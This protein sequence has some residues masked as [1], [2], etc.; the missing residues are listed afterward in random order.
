MINSQKYIIVFGLLFSLQSLAITQKMRDLNQV[1][2]ILMLVVDDDMQDQTACKMNSSR[3]ISLM[4]SAKAK[5]DSEIKKMIKMNGKKNIFFKV[6]TDQC[7]TDC[8]CGL[9]AYIGDTIGFEQLTDT[10]KLTH[11]KVSTIAPNQSKEFLQQC[12]LKNKKLCNS[13]V[14][15]SIKNQ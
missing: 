6:N 10:D 14:F 4:Q 12:A 11:R 3:A 2:N 9:Y 1:A 13:K 8:D 5:L 15:N 7:L